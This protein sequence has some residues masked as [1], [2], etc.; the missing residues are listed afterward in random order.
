[1]TPTAELRTKLRKYLNEAIPDGGTEFDTLF[2]DAEIDEF[3]E[4]ADTVYGAASTGWSIKAALLEK[5]IE[6][7]SVGAESYKLT[8]LKDQL[9]HAT[10]MEK[11]FAAMEE[12]ATGG[13]VSRLLTVKRPDVLGSDA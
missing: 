10:A 12:K 1:M 3:L 8:S 13:N 9:E 7:Y 5:D 2:T 6:S 4:E 11:K